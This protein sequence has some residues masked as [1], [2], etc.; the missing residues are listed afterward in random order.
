M[1]NACVSLRPLCSGGPATGG[2]TSPQRYLVFSC[3][4]VLDQGLYNA[5]VPKGLGLR[6]GLLQTGPG[7]KQK[8][9]Q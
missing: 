8:W 6:A 1:L 9:F 3:Y 2:Q 7:P 4:G 5:R